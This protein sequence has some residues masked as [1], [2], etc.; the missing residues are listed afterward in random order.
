VEL[1]RLEE[2]RENWVGAKV[3][4]QRALDLLPTYMEA[5]LAL[6]D[7][8]R[9]VESAAAAVGILVDIL[10]AEPF[11]LDALLLLGKC[12]VDDARPER[13]VEAFERI[14]RFQPD[15][16]AALFHLG[17]AQARLRRYA[18]AIQAWERTILADPAGPHAQAARSN[19]RSAKDLQ[20][21]FTPQAH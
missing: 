17:A 20:R 3:A 18:E 1:G 12:L 7:L 4:Y 11:D 5:A 14:L 21:I 10:A 15:H 19:A 6:A 2:G 13:A 8:V 16:S 9:R